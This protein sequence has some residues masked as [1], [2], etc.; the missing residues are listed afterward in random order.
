MSAQQLEDSSTAS[1][2]LQLEKAQFDIISKVRA[3][4][5]LDT[6][7]QTTISELRQTLLV[8]RVGVLRLNP[9]RGWDEGAFIAESVHSAFDSVLAKHVV[10][11][12]FGRDHAQAYQDGRIHAV[13]DIYNSGLS[14]CH[15][16]ILRQFQVRANL[17]VPLLSGSSLWGLLCVHQCSGPRRW[18]TDEIDFVAKLTAHLG[19]AIEHAELV[20]AKQRQADEL[21]QALDNIKTLHTRV[22]HT[23]KM[24]SLA[25]LTAGIAHEVNNPVNF[26]HGNLRHID[27]QVKDLLDVVEL[28]QKHYP[29]C[30][31][32]IETL[33]NELDVG[34]LRQDLPNVLKSMGNGSRRIT[35]IVQALKSFSHIDEAAYK[36]VDLHQEIEHLLILVNSRLQAA[37]EQPQIHIEKCFGTLPPINCFPAQLNQVI[38][39]IIDNAIDALRE[40]V[41]DAAPPKIT[42]E[43]DTAPNGVCLTISN[44]GPAIPAEVQA[45][46]FDPFFTTKPVGQGTGMGLAICDRIIAQHQGRIEC[47]S[48]D[49][50]GTAFLITLPLSGAEPEQ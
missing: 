12:C 49:Q 25:Q 2:S 11:H 16:D 36:A 45:K 31:P 5:N 20:E 48:N 8:D 29:D 35:S 27:A 43:T 13:E 34:F 46:L 23:E 9:C 21:S 47:V 24:V 37:S 42:I 7:F 40:R 28:Y 14:P 32:D 4:L 33:S 38:M 18:Q 39:S 41:R 19:V 26:I 1:L 17:L 22:A 50:Q 3:S 10:D 6:I 15:I 44:N 30:H